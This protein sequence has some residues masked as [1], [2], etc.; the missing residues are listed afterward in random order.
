[1]SRVGGVKHTTSMIRNEVPTVKNPDLGAPKPQFLP[2]SVALF[3]VSPL[4]NI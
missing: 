4:A 2:D 3:F 1:M